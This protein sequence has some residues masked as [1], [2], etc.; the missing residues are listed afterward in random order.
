MKRHYSTEAN[1]LQNARAALASH[2]A[3][4]RVGQE[5]VDEMYTYFRPF[6]RRDTQKVRQ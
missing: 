2:V 6:E 1:E 3:V 4:Q 5:K